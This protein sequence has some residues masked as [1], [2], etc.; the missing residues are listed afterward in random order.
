MKIKKITLILLWVLSIT[1][2]LTPKLS[3]PFT[4]FEPFSIEYFVISFIFITSSLPV[5]NNK[6]LEN[7]HFFTTIFI[8]LLHPNSYIFGRDGTPIILSIYLLFHLWLVVHKSPEYKLFTTSLIISFFLLDFGISVVDKNAKK[9]LTNQK[10]GFGVIVSGLKEGGYL[11]PN[12][13]LNIIG[14]FKDST[15]QTNSFGF[16]NKNETTYKKVE[17]TQRIILLGDSFV[18]GYRTDQNHTI[19]KVLENKLNQQNN[20][21]VLIAGSEHPGQYRQYIKKYAFKF[22]PDI[23]IVGITIGNDISQAYLSENR[24]SFKG[25]KII[26]SLLPEDAFSINRYPSSTLLRLD[27]NFQ[28][29]RIYKKFKMMINK[30]GIASWYQDYPGHVH[31]FDAFHSLGHFY[32]GNI[33][34]VNK[35]FKTLEKIILDI[36]AMTDSKK[37]KLLIAIFPQRFQINSE[38]W[39]A[40]SYAYGLNEKL[41]DLN[42]PNHKI[43]EFCLKNSI[44]CLDIADNFKKAPNI[45]YFLPNGDMHWNSEGQ[46]VAASAIYNFLTGKNEFIQK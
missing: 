4:F 6:I 41:F 46:K 15:I 20:F 32:N 19:G 33:P 12:L 21:E 27:R 43:K 22:S 40:V 39:E 36:K 26:N 31:L 29:W 9:A 23:I 2:L 16:R 37:T 17:G 1:A 28:K 42:K 10:G 5:R 24:L 44:N 8:I 34:L 18:A 11:V 30:K 14:E 45:S 13:N 38:E 35:S 7:I 25:G 3:L